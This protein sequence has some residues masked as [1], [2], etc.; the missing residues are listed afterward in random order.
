MKDHGLT[1]AIGDLLRDMFS[2]APRPTG[3]P[4]LDELLLYNY[5]A[6]TCDGCGEKPAHRHGDMNHCDRCCQARAREIVAAEHS[7]PS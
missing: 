5:E 6:T 4:D 2:S 1:R 3:N 7:G